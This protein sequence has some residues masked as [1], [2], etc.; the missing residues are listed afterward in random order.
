[1]NLP[2]KVVERFAQNRRE[3]AYRTK[4]GNE[5]R[6]KLYPDR[7]RRLTHG[8]TGSP[9]YLS[10]SMML[11]R[12]TNKKAPNFRDYGGRG[13]TVCRRWLRFEN[14]FADMGTRPAGAS[15]GRLNNEKNYS[16]DNCA[17]Q[18]RIEQNNNM[19]SSAL[20]SWRGETLTIANWARRLQMSHKLL[21]SRMQE[22]GW[23]PE[24]AFTEPVH[25]HCWT[26]A[27]RKNRRER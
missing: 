11:Q 16:P 10:W 1:M 20:I 18:T 4:R 21:R 19:R 23:S 14:F 12:C 13:I 7:D 22:H 15:L 3:H 17:W 8:M 26:N 6:R 2:A 5:R 9:E 24:R 25:T 27:V